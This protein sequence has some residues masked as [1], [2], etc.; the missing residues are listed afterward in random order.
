MEVRDAISKIPSNL[1]YADDSEKINER[2]E[3]IFG[4]MKNF[5]LGGNAL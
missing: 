4:W 3:A 2:A 5:V 1:E